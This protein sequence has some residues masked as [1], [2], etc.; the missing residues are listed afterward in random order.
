MNQPGPRKCPWTSSKKRK[1][2]TKNENTA[3]SELSELG[4]VAS[5]KGS[6]NDDSHS[7]FEATAMGSSRQ[8]IE[9]RDEKG[10]N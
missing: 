6:C 5:D 8:K 2:R 7:E 4:F 1:K 9:L 10:R 3:S